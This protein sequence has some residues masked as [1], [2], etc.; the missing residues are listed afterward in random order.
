MFL[1]EQ[2]ETLRLA[3][4]CANVPKYILGNLNSNFE[5]RPYQHDAFENFITYFENPKLRRKPTQTLFHMA[6]GS[7]KTLIMAGLMLYLYKKGYRDFLF[8]VNLTN[9]VNKTKDNFLNPANTKY[10]FGRNIAIDGENIIIKEV[11]N[12]QY[13]DPNAINIRFTTTQGLHS[14]MLMPKENAV[15]FDDFKERKIVLISDESHHINASTKKMNKAEEADYNS[16]EYT[17]S[18]IFEANNENVLLEFTA[19]CDL[20]NREIRAKYENKIV[21]D[22]PLIK[23]H[24][25]KYSKGIKTLRSD[26]PIMDRVLQ[27]CMLSQYRLKIFQ[28][29]RLAIKPVIMLKAKR[30]TVD[31]K[32]GEKTAN[33]WME[34]FIQTISSL[35]G[36]T[37]SRIADASTSETMNAVY[38]YFADKGITFDMLAQELRDEFSEHHCISANDEKEAERNQIILNSLEDINNPYRAVFAVN[39][40]DEGWDVLNLFDIVRLYETRQSGGKNISPATISEAQLIGRGARY[41][42][43]K[44]TDDQIKYQRKYDHDLENPLRIC[45]ELYYHCQNDSR[46]I[47]EL[48]N[49]LREIG[50]DLDKAV[51]RRYTLKDSF[52]EDTLY[53]HGFVFA[54]EPYKVSRNDMNSLPQSVLDWPFSVRLATGRGG[55]DVILEDGEV[56]EGSSDLYT[57]HTTLGD[58]AKLNYA[59]VHKALRHHNVF[60]FNALKSRF[61]NINSVRDFVFG[62]RYLNCIK[63]DI[64][65]K[66]HKVPPPVLYDACVYVLSR[67]AETV[68]KIDDVYKGSTNFIAKEIR[69]VFSDKTAL[70]TDPTGEGRGISQGDFSIPAGYR[71]DLSKED[72]YVF[73]DNYGTSEEK[74]FVAYFKTY[75]NHLKEIYDKV[76]LVRNERQL[77]IYSF[78]SGERFEPDYLLF[79]HVKKTDGY[80]QYQIFI[81]PKGTHLISKEPWKEKFLLELESK[82]VP[83]KKFVDDNKYL[84]WGFHFYNHEERVR[85][86]DEDFKRML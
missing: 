66:Y 4:V 77:K 68:E 18:R 6:T 72:W 37:L 9:I 15:T 11:E 59:F 32:T 28:D 69:K 82:A 40:L 35:S 85:E 14:D 27:A 63:V 1:Y 44:L 7:G 10:L 73:N 39:K 62:D 43:F 53:K 31:T 48:H 86:F 26:M 33:E 13:S 74:M 57:T 30:S 64:T 52:K 51:T 84:I 50:L 41:C 49:A 22:Y 23:F 19:T 46:Y 76:F 47:G 16:W 3:G 54:N 67:I 75:A 65:S 61:P 55:E 58:I 80:E 21:F 20:N 29:N 71:L 12:F 70:Y 42:P 24:D 8:F 25:D 38:R 17:V 34:M 60:R 45:E 2:L 79:L 83:V 5:L 78:E 81:E 56:S 36:V